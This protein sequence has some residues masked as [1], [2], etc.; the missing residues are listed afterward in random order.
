M[1]IHKLLFILLLTTLPTWLIGWAGVGSFMTGGR[2]LAL[3]QFALILN[4]T[5]LLTSIKY[6]SKKPLVTFIAFIALVAGF[7][8]N[9]GLPILPLIQSEEGDAYTYP[10]F[11]Q[12]AITVWS[13]N[14][15]E[16]SNS[17]L[18][19]KS[20]HFLCIQPYTGFGL[21]DLLWNKLK[22]PQHG[23]IAPK[24]TKST[25]I[26]KLL[27]YYKNVVIPV[28]T[29]DRVLPGPIGYTS[30]YTIPN[31]Y[32]TYNCRGRIYINGFYALYIN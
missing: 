22:I 25:E 12:G 16:F 9:Y 26:I 19:K 32:C 21:C 3:I 17:F 24:F 30:F 18:D 23:F 10:T 2:A 20:P 14:S 5:Y 13:L 11:S 1:K 27:A 6:D 15:I 8:F 4:M 31:D 28:P 29:N 7:V